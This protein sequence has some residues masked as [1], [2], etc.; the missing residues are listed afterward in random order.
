MSSIKTEQC[1][2]DT[3]QCAAV[4]WWFLELGVWGDSL[5]EVQDG[6]MYA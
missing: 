6:M 1:I 4:S 5:S 2:P 3:K